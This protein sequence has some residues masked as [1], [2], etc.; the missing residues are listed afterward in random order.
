[1]NLYNFSIFDKKNKLFL[2]FNFIINY[3]QS[4]NVTL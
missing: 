4:L 3:S 2:S 1:M